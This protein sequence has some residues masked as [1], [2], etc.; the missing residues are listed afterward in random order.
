[1][2]V[3]DQPGRPEPSGE[4]L[5]RA[6]FREGI[7]DKRVFVI[8][9]LGPARA[10]RLGNNSGRTVNRI[11]SRRETNYYSICPILFSY[12]YDALLHE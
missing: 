7:G 3:R 10:P 11:P 8:Y 6:G 9:S 12:S 2:R 5:D 1:M 4:R